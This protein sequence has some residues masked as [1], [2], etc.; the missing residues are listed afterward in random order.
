M[1][2]PIPPIDVAKAAFN[3]LV[4]RA[5][6]GDTALPDDS[7]RSILTLDNHINAI[8]ALLT[9][10]VTEA[11][12]HLSTLKQ[13]RNTLAPIHGLP[14]EVLVNVWLHCVED[15]SCN[16]SHLDD[17]LSTLALVCKSWHRGVLDHSVL[18]CYLQDTCKSERYNNWVLRKSRNHPLH[19][20]LLAQDAYISDSL[21]NIA[22]PE[23]H[24]WKS[25]VLAPRHGSGTSEP[26]L[27]MLADANLENLTRF[28]I[29]PRTSWRE[30]SPISLPATP[31][32]GE[33]KLERFPLYW[34][35]F[36]APQLRA[37]RIS[38]LPIDALSLP[39]LV[40]LLRSTPFLEILLLRDS[41]IETDPPEIVPQPKP[42]IV[43]PRL[44]TL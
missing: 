35:A 25:F 16:R 6:Q 27:D 3:M 43:L 11:N 30:P 20:R 1:E 32:L 42:P 29:Q 34:E 39:Q 2:S 18:W 23:S 12:D 44:R 17:Q 13:S 31:A 41:D 36:N 15:A 26:Y 5:N 10:L 37:L 33:V 19:L 22:M 24:R 14:D 4:R 40:N 28:E 9:F 7:S 8:E 21:L 38:S